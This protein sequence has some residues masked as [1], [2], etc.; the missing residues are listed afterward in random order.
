M[1]R[2]EM[3]ERQ[4]EAFEIPQRPEG[5]YVTVPLCG[6]DHDVFYKVTNYTPAS[7]T[8]EEAHGVIVQR[9]ESSEIELD[10]LAIW[11]RDNERPM[12]DNDIEVVKDNDN[13]MRRIED[14]A[15]IAYLE[16]DGYDG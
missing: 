14:A 13:F 2:S 6:E 9:P 15:E 16:D 8:P 5:D 11:D 4:P 7:S 12:S 1:D 3:F 10:I